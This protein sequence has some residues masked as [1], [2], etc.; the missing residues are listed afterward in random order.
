[1]SSPVITSCPS[2]NTTCSGNTSVSGKTDSSE[3]KQKLYGTCG[4]PLTVNTSSEKVCDSENESD[5]ETIKSVNSS[6]HSIDIHS[7]EKCHIDLFAESNFDSSR[8]IQTVRT[9][10]MPYPKHKLFDVKT[11]HEIDRKLFLY[12]DS[13]NHDKILN[14]IS[15]LNLGEFKCFYDKCGKKEDTQMYL[16]YMLVMI[17]LT[18]SVSSEQYESINE[19]LM[20]IWVF[21]K[22]TAKELLDEPEMRELVDAIKNNDSVLDRTLDT[23]VDKLLNK[24]PKSLGLDQIITVEEEKPKIR[25]KIIGF[26]NKMHEIYNGTNFISNFSKKFRE[27]YEEFLDSCCTEKQE[28]LNK[29]E[30][31]EHRIKSGGCKLMVQ[32]VSDL[33]GIGDP[34]LLIENLTL[35]S[36]LSYDQQKNIRNEIKELTNDLL[37]LEAEG[38]ILFNDPI[39]IWKEIFIGEIDPSQLNSSDFYGI[40]ESDNKEDVERKINDWFD[41]KMSKYIECLERFDNKLRI[42]KEILAEHVVDDKDCKQFKRYIDLISCA[43]TGVVVWS[44]CLTHR[45]DQNL[46]SSA[47]K[48]P[49]GDIKA[50][51][52]WLLDAK[53]AYSINSKV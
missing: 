32:G 20:P 7:P 22:Y 45:Y 44:L 37:T 35:N 21:N 29:E 2:P 36:K 41:Q 27:L 5:N 4:S 52:E 33:L 43:I 14:K 50:T 6:F 48:I 46:R 24:K 10:K 1:M 25:K 12:L 39:S 40:S 34:D 23:I 53:A 42:L 30:Q 16:E 38:N 9:I 31:N 17:T 47:E 15:D 13:N 11:P 28:G 8:F 3:S 26:A 51:I 49:L 18:E 19:F